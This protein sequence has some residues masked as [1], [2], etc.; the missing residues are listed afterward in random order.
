MVGKPKPLLRMSTQIACLY[1]Y[2]PAPEVER[3]PPS[4]FTGT[5]DVCPREDA[6]EVI[7]V[8]PVGKVVHAELQRNR[9]GGF[10]HQLISACGVKQGT[11]LDTAAVEIQFGGNARIDFTAGGVAGI[12]FGRHA[13]IIAAS[14]SGPEAGLVR[15]GDTELA[16]VTLVLVAGKF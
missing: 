8:E 6:A 16:F 9:V 14:K 13:T 3:N 15:V 1:P 10:P 5:A 4:E 11:R 7:E 2:L 12:D